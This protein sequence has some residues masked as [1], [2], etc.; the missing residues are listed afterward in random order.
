M[1][2]LR[3]ITVV[4]DEEGKVK[5]AQFGSCW[6]EDN[7]NC[8]NEQVDFFKEFVSSKE[9]L[10]ILK[11]GIGKISFFSDKEYIDYSSYGQFCR[12]LHSWESR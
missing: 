8:V 1:R 3:T 2:I 5:I 11:K 12:S 10:S 6:E 4:K 9:E 7:P